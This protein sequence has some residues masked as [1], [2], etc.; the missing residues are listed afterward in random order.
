MDS[1]HGL[2]MRSKGILT[3]NILHH[4]FALWAI[5]NYLQGDHTDAIIN[6]IAAL[7][8][9]SVVIRRGWAALDASNN[10]PTPGTAQGLLFVPLFN[11]YWIFRGVAGLPKAYNKQV[12]DAGRPSESINTSFALVI[13]ILFCVHQALLLVPSMQ[14]LANLVYICYVGFS[15]TFLW[16]IYSLTKSLDAQGTPANVEPE[17]MH[18]VAVASI[19]IGS[20]IVGAI[21]LV[22]AKSL[23]LP[24]PEKLISTLQSRGYPTKVVDRQIEVNGMGRVQIKEIR[25]YNRGANP[26]IF[27]GLDRIGSIG[28]VS[29]GYNNDQ[30]KL[31]GNA[32][33][34]SPE[35]VNEVIYFSPHK[36]GYTGEPGV[37]DWLS[38][39]N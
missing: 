31:I 28:Y 22:L 29:S 33:G 24:S 32:M 7:G 25:V 19:V 39:F 34:S 10:N 21:I 3:L 8:L 20:A 18:T 12:T 13:A 27:S 11:F 1:C 38:L 15:V 26:G 5:F 4:F 36:Q 9:A 6:G 2:S 35:R 14:S 23:L 17:K 16:Q 37:V 30:A